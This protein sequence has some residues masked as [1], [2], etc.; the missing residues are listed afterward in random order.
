MGGRFLFVSVRGALCP[1]AVEGNQSG[2]RGIFRR[3]RRM[4]KEENNAENFSAFY[5]SCFLV[6][7]FKIVDTAA[8]M[9]I[10]GRTGS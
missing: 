2:R 4:T 7:C 10:I 6:F 9:R 3:R 5:G 1:V 8:R